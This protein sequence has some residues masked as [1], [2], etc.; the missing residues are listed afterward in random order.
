MNTIPMLM[1]NN[2]SFE[3]NNIF[4]DW[5]VQIIIKA[6]S[7]LDDDINFAI[8]Y[9]KTDSKLYNYKISKFVTL[10]TSYQLNKILDI[11]VKICIDNKHYDD[12]INS[13][14]K[15]VKK[16]KFIHFN[17]KWSNIYKKITE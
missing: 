14:S 1:F 4:D 8:H 3:S 15:Y 12:L 7:F 5:N 6:I 11:I 13:L 16:Q 17:L 9:D 10:F 2:F